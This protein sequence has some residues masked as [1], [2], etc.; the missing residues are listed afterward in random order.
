MVITL[1]T[2]QKEK[3]AMARGYIDPTRTLRR[4]SWTMRSRIYILVLLSSFLYV[5]SHSAFAESVEALIRQAG[6]A[7]QHHFNLRD[8]RVVR[9]HIRAAGQSRGNRHVEIVE[10]SGPQRGET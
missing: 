2:L 1:A 3:I 8:A 4:R 10:I 7:V 9:W 6:N 5:L